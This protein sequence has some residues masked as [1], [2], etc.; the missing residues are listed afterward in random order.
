MKTRYS[1]L[2]AWVGVLALALISGTRYIAAPHIQDRTRLSPTPPASV[3]SAV[4][5]RRSDRRNHHLPEDWQTL[6]YPIRSIR[7]NSKADNVACLSVAYPRSFLARSVGDG[8]TVQLVSGDVPGA[9]V[10]IT[11]HALG[12][13]SPAEYVD[14]L[15]APSVLHRIDTRG[16]IQPITL[17]G[18]PSYRVMTRSNTTTS[19]AAFV[20][21]SEV[22]VIISTSFAGP[23]T[24]Q[25][26][27]LFDLILTSMSS[28]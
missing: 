11:T 22:I 19:L 13:Q 15:T 21:Y 27:V 26:T 3:G 8:G 17:A 6:S 7:P 14:R 16:P 12:R 24:H 2:W 25:Q 18:I 9:V 20:P 23:D 5:C 1:L 10:A 4:H 28:D